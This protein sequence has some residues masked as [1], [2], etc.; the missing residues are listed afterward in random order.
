MTKAE[1]N[2][3]IL[4]GLVNEM[5]LKHIALGIDGGANPYFN[6][7]WQIDTPTVIPPTPPELGFDIM[8]NLDSFNTTDIKTF[9]FLMI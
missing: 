9:L 5:T 6:F 2:D 1:G 3:S 8:I 7:D 4:L